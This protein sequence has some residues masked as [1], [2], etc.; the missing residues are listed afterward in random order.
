M[1]KVDSRSV[2]IEYLEI[3]V[4][5]T[6]PVIC[7]VIESHL[8][9]LE[10]RIEGVNN[11]HEIDMNKLVEIVLEKLYLKLYTSNKL[12]EKDYIKDAIREIEENEY[13]SA[14][15]IQKTEE[16]TRL[17]KDRKERF[18]KNKSEVEKDLRRKGYIVKFLGKIEGN[19]TYLFKVSGGKEVRV[20]VPMY[21]NRNWCITEKHKLYDIYKANDVL[22]LLVEKLRRPITDEDHPGNESEEGEIEFIEK[23]P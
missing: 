19:D 21:H 3:I 20:E 9:I 2:K 23:R 14:K 11:I 4:Y 13:I 18:E 1:D 5:N 7:R 6:K 16:M 17:F 8:K 22:E 15:T 10:F 12:M